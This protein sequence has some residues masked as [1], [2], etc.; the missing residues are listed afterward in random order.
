VIVKELVN[1]SSARTLHFAAKSVKR[2][3]FSQEGICHS[4]QGAER[5]GDVWSAPAEAERR[6]FHEQM[7]L[8]FG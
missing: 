1:D 8:L 3:K 2:L 5:P 4:P 7:P 6:P